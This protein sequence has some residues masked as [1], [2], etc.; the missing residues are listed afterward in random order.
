[1]IAISGSQFYYLKLTEIQ[2]AGHDY[3]EFFLIESFEMERSMFNPD[4]WGRGEIDL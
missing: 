2:V 3:V 4:I 1:V